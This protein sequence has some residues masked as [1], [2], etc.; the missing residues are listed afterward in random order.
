[1]R[2]AQTFSREQQKSPSDA[3]AKEAGAMIHAAAAGNKSRRP[4]T[5]RVLVVDDHLDTAESLSYLLRDMGHEVEF[6]I[7][8]YAALEIAAKFRPEIVFLDLVLPD[9]DGCDLS[10]LLRLRAAAPMRI[11]AFTGRGSD[12]VRRRAEQAGCDEYLLKPLDP[13][14]VEGLLSR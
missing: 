1:M 10:R 7:N 13:R 14:L 12:E 4:D 3:Q 6:A 2:G 5:R 9:F 11:I 8:G